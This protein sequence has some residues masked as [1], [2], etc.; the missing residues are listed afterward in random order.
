V[1]LRP[2]IGNRVFGC[3]DCQLICPWNRYARLSAEAD[4]LPR[5][6]LDNAKLWEL[7]AWSEEEFL[8]KT[9][10]SPIRRTGYESFLRNIAVGLG[11]APTSAAVLTALHQRRQD[12]SEVVREHVAWALGRHG[13][14][15]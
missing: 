14:I 10:G 1:E 15:L 3:D 8:K 11:N 13:H 7:F 12:P 2:L 6:G 4:F 5:H 9:E